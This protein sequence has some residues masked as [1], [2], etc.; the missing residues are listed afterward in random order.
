M[1]SNYYSTSNY[2]WQHRWRLLQI[3]KIIESYNIHQAKILDIGATSVYFSKSFVDDNEIYVLDNN[4]K[5]LDK[6]KNQG[7][8]CINQN[9]NV[10]TKI[11]FESN[12]FDI[13]L[14]FDVFE[15]L[16]CPQLVLEEIGRLLADGGTFFCSFPNSV[17][18][19]NR[20]TFALGKLQDITDSAHLYGDV[21]SDHLHLFNYSKIKR[22]W[23]EYD[24]KLLETSFFSPKTV[25]HSKFRSLQM[26]LSL[27]NFLKLYKI[28]PNLFAFTFICVCRRH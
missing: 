27:L 15:H 25:R 28:F 2:A 4:V 24:F 22:I 18:L 14:C 16:H 1:A 5:I 17:N 6:A 19:Y 7:S 3:R 26:V 8:N 20:I 9:L 12:Y 21:F 10:E 13:I 11:N 23:Q